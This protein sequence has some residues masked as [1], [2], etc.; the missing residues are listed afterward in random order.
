M[1]VYK[2]LCEGSQTGKNRL[3]KQERMAMHTGSQTG[4][5]R[6]ETIGVTEVSEE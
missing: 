2:L 1:K 3:G 5:I 6:N 4:R